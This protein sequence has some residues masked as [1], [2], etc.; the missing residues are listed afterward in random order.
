MIGV[1]RAQLNVGGAILGLV[2][3]GSMRKQAEQ[4]RGNKSVSTLLHGLC[5]SSCL[6]DP[7]LSSCP[8]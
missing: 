8:G 5:I 7:A 3:L 6:Q 1:W 4:A 2:I